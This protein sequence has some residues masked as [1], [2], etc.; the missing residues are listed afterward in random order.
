MFILLMECE[1]KHRTMNQGFHDNTYLEYCYTQWYQMPYVPPLSVYEMI[2][3]AG[4][5]INKR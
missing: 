1:I 2:I 3:E 5:D 4:A